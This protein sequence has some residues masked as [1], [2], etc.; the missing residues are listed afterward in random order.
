MAV[1][2]LAGFRARA[3]PT[4]TFQAL[5]GS[6]FHRESTGIVGL[7][8]NPSENAA[9]LF[10]DEKSQ[11]Q[12][13]ERTQPTLPMGLG[14]GEGVTHDYRRHGTTRSAAL[15]T[16]KGKVLTQCRPRH[17][18]QEYLGFLREI[19]KTS[20]CWHASPASVAIRSE[21]YALINHPWKTMSLRS[22]RSSEGTSWSN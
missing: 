9:V 11:I 6:I 10:V 20:N 16:A 3:T 13:L 12:A 5:D 19:E 7:Y 1:P 4:E 21:R 15:D 22:V 17:R 8:L 18:H 2:H 14:Y